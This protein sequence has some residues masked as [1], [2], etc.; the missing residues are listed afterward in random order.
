MTVFAA[1][2]V[3]I[4]SASAAIYGKAMWDPIELVGHF[5]SRLV[6]GIAMFTVVIAT[7]SVNIAANVVSPAND[8]ANLAPK[9]ISFK[10]GG[11]I[12][13]VIGVLMMPWKLIA[14]LHS[15]IFQWLLGYSGGLGSIAGV[16]VCNYWFIRNKRLVLAD[17]Y[18]E[19]G[20]YTYTSGVNAPVVIA[21]LLGCGLA[22]IVLIVK[23]LRFLR[24]CVVRGRTRR[25]ALVLA[26]HA[27]QS[28]RQPSRGVTT[29]RERE[30]WSNKI[31]WSGSLNPD[32]PP[33]LCESLPAPRLRS[34]KGIDGWFSEDEGR[35]Y[36]RF[37]RSLTGGTFVEVGSWKGRSTSFI[38]PICNA[39]GT[40]LVCVDHWSG[41]IDSLKERYD[42]ALARE[43]VEA[44]FRRNMDQLGI[45]VE[46][47]AEPSLVAVHRFAPESIDR[48]FLD[49]SHDAESVTADLLAWS[50]RL[51]PDGLLGGHD[52]S[53]KH[54][55][56]CA[57]VDAFAAERG[58]VVLRGPRSVYSFAATA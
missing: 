40:R 23:P 17:L 44:T 47:M 8:F 1:M 19:E 4:T 49:G 55:A 25:G 46:V 13:G 54:P 22:W 41:S 14:D 28:P 16:L 33:S 3:I 30:N 51:K 53:H 36:A 11:I 18:R 7:L 29:W 32:P 42:E 21:T 6:V 34:M 31:K 45:C 52:Y 37:A 27:G 9:R 35:W 15:Y 5:A 48:V 58:L 50:T 2:G 43:N 20:A 57:A 10:I 26:R 12:T 38:G 24:L 39:N 56:L